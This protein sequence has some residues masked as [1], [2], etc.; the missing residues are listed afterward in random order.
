[1]KIALFLSLIWLPG[2]ALGQAQRTTAQAFGVSVNTSTINQKTPAA[3]APAE[4]GMAQNESG[5][6]TIASMVTAHNAYAVASGSSDRSYSNAVGNASL[7]TVIILDG[8]ITATGVVAIATSTPDGNDFNGSS[9]SNLVVNG[10][11]MSAPEPNT[12]V[13][14]PDVGY[15]VLNERISTRSGITVNMIHVVLDQNGRYGAGDII[16]GSASSNVK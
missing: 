9:V 5:E 6:V 10:V 3:V 4:D 14:L 13:D 1:M 7:G 11:A 15:V 16:V 8:L 2:V 12:R